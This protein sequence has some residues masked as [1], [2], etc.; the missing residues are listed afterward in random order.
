MDVGGTSLENGDVETSVFFSY[1]RVNRL[2]AMPV[3]QF[4]EDAGFSVWWDGMLEGGTEFLKHTEAALD[5]AKAVVVLWSKD[6]VSSHWVRD[7]ATTGRERQRLIPLSLDGTMPPLG[8][9]QIQAIDMRKWR[10]NDDAK[11][12]LL[13]RLSK[14]HNRSMED[15]PHVS[16]L[17]QTASGTALSK[18]SIILGGSAVLLLGTAGLV[19]RNRQ[20]VSFGD[21][22]VLPFENLS[23]DEE[24]SYLSDGLS[25]AIRD[26]LARNVALKITARSSSRE[27]SRSL[28]DAVSIAKTLKVDTL[29]EGRLERLGPEDRLTVSLI[30]GRDGLVRWTESFPFNPNRILELRDVITQRVASSMSNVGGMTPSE[31][32]ID[33]AAY[34]QYLRGRA[35]LDRGATLERVQLARGH[36]ERAV[37]IDPAF[38]LAHANLAEQLLLLGSVTADKDESRQLIEGAV[39]SAEAGVRATPDLA[40]THL[41]LGLARMSGQGDFQSAEEAYETAQALGLRLTKDIA[42]YAIFKAGIGHSDVA[43]RT[44][45]RGVARD[46][47]N[48]MIR[49]VLAYSVY[50]SGNFKES[51]RLYRYV[52]DMD[53]D[54]Y[55]VRAW[56][57]L[58]EIYDGNH[59]EGLAI[60]R[61]EKNQMEQLTCQAIAHYRLGNVTQGGE[62]F[63]ELVE[64]YG[65]AAAYQQAQILSQSGDLD[66]AMKTLH[67]AEEL[68][69]TGL[70][71]VKIDPALLPLRGR[72]DFLA[73][74]ARR[75][76]TG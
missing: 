48:A 75:G 62:S 36:F 31:Q 30:K 3:I 64:I 22:A 19:L 44:A 32:N 57:G 20:I 26:Q 55:N 69:D 11:R 10:M 24:L 37:E 17:S 54:R 41:A 13:R 14:L 12:Q 51:A 33:P 50:T 70:A 25:S 63:S 18:R 35:L 53:P 58:S 7:E 52:L 34:D 71:L 5:R 46:P 6:S 2:Q 45:R 23:G 43:I 9:R 38:G 8:F 66:G 60:C 47:L 49:E 16:M 67:R 59:D 1:S 61:E 68:Q 76:L 40:T 72:N 56:L 15:Y 29:L 21:L 42:R 28:P 4:I 65:D 74:L 73:L 39:Q 27:A